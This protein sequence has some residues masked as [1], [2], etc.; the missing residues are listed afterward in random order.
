[1]AAAGV[2]L[3]ADVPEALDQG[4]LDVSVDV[5]QGGGVG[6]LPGLDLGADVV[7]GGDNLAGLVGGGQAGLGEPVGVGLA[8]ADVLGVQ[9]PVVSDRLGE[10]FDAP[11]GVAGEATAPGFLTHG[12]SCMS[13]KGN[14]FRHATPGGPRPQRPAGKL[15]SSERAGGFLSG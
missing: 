3:A 6:E 13:A 2:E 1:A 5:L 12:G 10:G 15:A 14:A 11:V 8:G 9:A 7:E 4:P